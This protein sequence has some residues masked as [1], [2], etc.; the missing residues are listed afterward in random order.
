MGKQ[1]KLFTAIASAAVVGTLGAC[2]LVPELSSTNPEGDW[3]Y[4]CLL[5]SGEDILY[6]V[7]LNG[8]NSSEVNFGSEVIPM[9][10][11]E[12]LR[13]QLPREFQTR[14][15]SNQIELTSLDGKTKVLIEQAS[16]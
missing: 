13:Q 8:G 5:D 10:I 4:S 7:R 12:K 15:I 11:S 6:H 3:N 14:I 16:E 2:S 1:M 9:S